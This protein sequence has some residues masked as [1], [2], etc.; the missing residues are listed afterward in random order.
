MF[1]LKCSA[2]QWF[3]IFYADEKESRSSFRR[4]ISEEI[5]TKVA[6][7]CR[8]VP[9]KYNTA[10]NLRSHFKRFGEVTKVF[11]NQAKMQAIVHF[12]THVRTLCII[13]F[14]TFSLIFLTIR[15]A[16]WNHLSPSM[17]SVS[18]FFFVKAIHLGSVTYLT[19]WNV[20]LKLMILI[21][22]LNPCL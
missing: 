11:P 3:A 2:W 20:A 14:M 13:F 15:I 17:V 9:H 7:V 5:S 21:R 18:V 4:Q 22:H 1:I 16:V 19:L 6:I 8:N 12:K 10:M